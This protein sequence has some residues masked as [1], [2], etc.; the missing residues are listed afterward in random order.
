[1]YNP[2]FLENELLVKLAAT[3]NK[4]HV[5]EESS[6]NK[7]AEFSPLSPLTPLSIVKPGMAN[8]DPLAGLLGND[9]TESSSSASQSSSAAQPA[10]ESK[11]Q[12]K[13][14]KKPKRVM[15]RG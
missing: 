12:K 9:T 5:K 15:I 7:R 14:A 8:V 4:M 1:M 11:R 6:G 2:P 13:L 10:P 3:I